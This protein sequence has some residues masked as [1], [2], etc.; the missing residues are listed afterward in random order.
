[1]L[2]LIRVWNI[3]FI[4]L[5]SVVSQPG[6][7]PQETGNMPFESLNCNFHKLINLFRKHPTSGILLKPTKWSQTVIN[8]KIGLGY[9]VLAIPFLW[10]EVHPWKVTDLYFRAQSLSEL[11]KQI[12]YPR[13]ALEVV[14][15]LCTQNCLFCDAEQAWGISCR[16]QLSWEFGEGLQ[17]KRLGALCY[18]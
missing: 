17:S 1:M 18:G 9:L 15:W 13:H 6:S 4:F 8:W 2:D 16:A 7:V 12:D 5:C 11:I 3:P 10:L 14:P